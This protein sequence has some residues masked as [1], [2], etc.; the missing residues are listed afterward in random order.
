MEPAHQDS[1]AV[2]AGLQTSGA[3]L[4]TG[5][6]GQIDPNDV[7][8]MRQARLQKALQAQKQLEARGRESS[9]EEDSVR[10][11]Q[12]CH[13]TVILCFALFTSAPPW[14]SKDQTSR[15]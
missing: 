3:G 6:A 9:S 4:A 10:S 1:D 8:A 11:L 15:C 12:H 7:A 13:H 2:T 14:N 5:A